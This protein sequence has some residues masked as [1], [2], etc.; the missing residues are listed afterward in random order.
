MLPIKNPVARLFIYLTL[1]VYV[2]VVSLP[3]V[4]TV[5]QSL[6]NL[7]QA[8]SR[9]PLFIFEPTLDS[10]IKL[11]FR[12]APANLPLLV[13][14]FIAANVAIVVIARLLLQR[15]VSRLIIGVLVLAGYSLLFWGIP[16]IADIADFYDFFVNTL[17]VTAGA[18][19]IALA[20]GAPAGYALARYH[21]SIGSVILIGALA[22]SSIP[23]LAYALPYY[24]IAAATGL[25]DSYLVLILVS[26]GLQQPFAI[27]ILRGFFMDIPREI[28]ESAYIDGAG[29]LTA[30]A[31][32]VMPIV[33]PGILSTGLLV[34][35]G[36]YHQFLIVRVLTRLNW[37]LPVAIT[38]YIGTVYSS[39]DTVP[40]AAAVSASIPLLIL[41]LFFQEQMV[42]GLAAGAVKG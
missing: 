19:I 23:G 18:V 42:K 34:A 2:A 39:I 37:T 20:I 40:F 10:Y 29:P 5:L 33:W 22:L 12:S 14:G 31:R 8:S 16:Q 32:V 24:Q 6:K 17:I 41:V 4:W 26:V 9:T 30:F 13:L 7:R 1:T 28:E 15:G 3:F 36:V 35:L 27:W 11:W 38:Q 21:G 25:Q